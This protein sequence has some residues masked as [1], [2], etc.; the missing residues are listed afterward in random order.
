MF[1]DAGQD[2]GEPSLRIN[3]IHL[4]RND[5]AV[6][7]RG[8]LATAIRA[9]EQPRFATQSYQPFILPMSGRK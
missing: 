6:H 5:Q 9:A 2:V 4:G 8:A 3:V 1:G 7:D